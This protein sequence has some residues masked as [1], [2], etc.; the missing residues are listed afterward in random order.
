M[1]AVFEPLFVRSVVKR[2]RTHVAR[3]RHVCRTKSCRAAEEEEGAREVGGL[4]DGPSQDAEPT[5]ST[6]RS[7]FE[8]TSDVGGELAH[9]STS[10]LDC[11][12]LLWW[13]R[14]YVSRSD[15]GAAA[16]ALRPASIR[17]QFA[18]NTATT[19]SWATAVFAVPTGCWR[20]TGFGVFFL[21]QNE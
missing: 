2:I 11:G 4:A 15:A 12:G 20:T 16:A 19:A 1:L 17:A 14:C 6:C 8:V 21:N 10:L 13:R 3:G 9:N 5:S 7:R 18:V